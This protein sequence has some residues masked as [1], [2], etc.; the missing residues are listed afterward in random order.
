M[1]WATHDPFI[2]SHALAFLAGAY[3]YRRLVRWTLGLRA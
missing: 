2:V 1:N 3:T